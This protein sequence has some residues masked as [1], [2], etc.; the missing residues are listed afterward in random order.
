MK[1]DDKIIDLT[2][3]MTGRITAV[4][5]NSLMVKWHNGTG[6]ILPKGCVSKGGLGYI[7]KERRKKC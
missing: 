5:R 1:I 7:Y 3:A 2:K 4:N 6:S